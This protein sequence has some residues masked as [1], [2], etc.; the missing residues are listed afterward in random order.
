MRRLNDRA[1][2]LL[3]AE[4]ERL[5]NG[6]LE[7]VRKDIVLRRLN[8]MR[9][10]E[11]T[12]LTYT[13]LKAAID[14]IFPEFD[15]KVLRRAARINQGSVRQ[16]FPG[17][18]AVG[19]AAIGTLVAV[20][21]IWVLNLPYPMI[22]WPVS[23][24]VPIVLLPSF[25]SMDQNYRQAIAS[26]EQA[27][28]L[29]NQA[30]SAQDIELGA[31][32]ARKAQH[33]LD[34]LPV[35]FLGYYPR[36]YCGLFGCTWQFTYDEFK[37]ARQDVGRMEAIVFQ[38]ENALQLLEEGTAAVEAAKQQ[39]QTAEGNQAQKE[40]IA[41]WQSGLDK[42]NEIPPNTLAGRMGQTKLQAYQRD[43]EQISG[44]Y[45]AG[46][47]NSTLIDAAMQFAW[48]AS[49]EAQ[50]PPHTAETW[51]RIADSWEDAIDR[52][53]QVPV[54]SDDYSEAQSRL[55]EY[56]N[57]L[58]II[59]ENQ[60]KEARSHAAF[61]SAQEKTVRLSARIDR[62]STTEY[63]SELQSILSELSEVAPQTTPYEDAQNMQQDV[64]AKLQ[65]AATQA[66]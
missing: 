6:P 9:L 1:Y 25:I 40:A 45:T 42:L 8:K 41:A 34:N 23:K 61:K 57:K 29:V 14:D 33:H 2:E 54:D 59:R 22:R 58:G 15:E 66:Q 47:R 21:G 18:G 36:T 7:A 48:I 27:D 4:V 38:E 56:K 52:L 10:Q 17:L 3:A 12:P 64:E 63:T 55:A 44:F 46:S 35:W 26:V 5:V 50:N 32:K 49:E 43:F 31:E 53:E 39:Y 51:Q 30:T 20:G 28:Q 19:T 37:T 60:A 11:G 65:S 13:D 16:R 24:T 62:L